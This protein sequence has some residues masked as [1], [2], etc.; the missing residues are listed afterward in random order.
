MYIPCDLKVCFNN[1][2]FLIRAINSPNVI[3]DIS[4]QYAVLEECPDRHCI[5]NHF[6]R[7]MEAWFRI[8]LGVFYQSVL[9]LLIDTLVPTIEQHNGKSSKTINLISQG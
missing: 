7:C 3:E 5:G 6:N 1:G 2:S 9:R 4:Y 8:K